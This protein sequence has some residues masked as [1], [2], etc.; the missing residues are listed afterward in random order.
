MKSQFTV[1][2]RVASPT[3]RP[4]FAHV[5]H[6][7][8][9]NLWRKTLGVDAEPPGL[10]HPSYPSTSSRWDRFYHF[11]GSVIASHAATGKRI[12]PL[13]FSETIISLD[14]RLYSTS[15]TNRTP[16]YN[17]RG[18]NLNGITWELSLPVLKSQL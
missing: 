13:A 3:C 14:W 4:T 17:L 9:S 5:A 2:L 12:H 10:N 11:A 8:W 7:E 16:N 1:E 15:V 6:L 18:I